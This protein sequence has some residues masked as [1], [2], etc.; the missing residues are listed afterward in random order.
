VEYGA[1]VLGFGALA[2]AVGVTALVLLR[3]G[4]RVIGSV[5]D[6]LRL[7]GIPHAGVLALTQMYSQ[8]SEEPWDRGTGT[9]VEKCSVRLGPA[10]HVG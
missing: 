4:H 3:I 1:P 9:E 10:L 7:P 6:A 8:P 2:L 5:Q